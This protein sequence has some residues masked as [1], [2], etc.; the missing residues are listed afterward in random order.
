MKRAAFF[1][2]VAVLSAVSIL[3]GACAPPPSPTLPPKV[4][5]EPELRYLLISNFGDIFYVDSDFYP[6]ARVGQEQVNAEQQF[7]SIRASAAEFSAILA[8]LGLAEKADYTADEKLSIYREHKK[9]SRGVEMT[10][11]GNVYNFVLRRG[12]GQGERIEGTV[13]TSGKIT[14]LKREPSFN[15]VPIC[16]VGGTVIDTPE[17]QLPVEQLKPGMSVWTL[18]AGGRRVVAA[19]EK[20]TVTPMPSAFRIVKII[21]N[22]GRSVTASPGHPSAEGRALGEYRV[23]ETLDGASVIAVQSLPYEGRATYDIL[24]DG[25]TGLYW[26][27][28]VLLMSTLKD[29]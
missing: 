5:S 18:D 16:L 15:T 6:V 21:L 23:G 3:A 11:S 8:H 19:I 17:G 13:T 27:N 28:G 9:L 22:D 2:G 4:Y 12:E 14:V 25:T 7:A 29:N 1:I 20:T 10:L 26:A 24:P